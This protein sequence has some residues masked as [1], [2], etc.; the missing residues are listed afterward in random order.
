MPDAPPPH[1]P[2]NRR[3][4]LGAIA[5]LPIVGAGAARAEGTPDAFVAIGDWGR[6]G[7]GSQMDVAAA[8]SDAAAQIGS[9]FVL[10]VG[11]NFYPAGVTSV[12]D[13]HWKR[14]FEDVYAAPSL[15]TP[16][17]VALGNHDYRG[18][19]QAQVDYSRLSPRWRMP[20]RYFTVA[21][22]D[23]GIADLDLFVIDTSP[24]VVGSDETIAQLVHGHLWLQNRD[25]QIAWLERSL[26]HSTAAWK[27]VVGHHPIHS[28]AHG[29]EPFLIARIKP[30]L[31]RH[32]VQVY[33]NGHDHDLQHIQRGGVNYVCTGA[34][35]DV[36]TVAPV[37]GT[38]FCLSRPGFA[39]FARRHD[40][41][42]LEFRDHGGR[43]L[44]Q[45]VIP[46]G[47]DRAMS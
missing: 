33:L 46:P 11:D 16:W 37:E 47:A 13:A 7:Q 21:G 10:S 40:G 19:P 43:T 5:A 6:M 20:S 27:I 28:G 23:L 18:V 39:M 35:A 44:Y 14:S 4:V 2:V 36:G 9:R 41:L 8:M 3:A 12:A 30:L 22:R 32:G 15:Q 31:E 29:D 42:A 26:S 1:M 45:A 38:K 24:L 34:G 17:Y 25:A